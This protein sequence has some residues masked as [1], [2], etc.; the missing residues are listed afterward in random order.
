MIEAMACGTPVIAYGHGAIPELVDDGRTGFI[1]HDQ[2]QAIA[3]A[4][5]LDRIDRRTCRA[6]FERRFAAPVMARQYLEKY[7]RLIEEPAVA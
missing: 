3:A 5:C 6:T 4:H 2:A 7:V 1:V